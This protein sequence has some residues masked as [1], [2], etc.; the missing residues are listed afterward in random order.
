MIVLTSRSRSAGNP[1]SRACVRTKSTLGDGAMECLER[2]VAE[3]AGA[4]YGVK[5]SFLFTMLHGHPRFRA[6]LRRMKLE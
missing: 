1:P 5:G 4:V 3:R 2:T 6:L